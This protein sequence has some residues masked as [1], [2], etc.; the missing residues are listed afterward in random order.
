MDLRFRILGPVEAC[1]ERR[2]L[3]LG[4]ARASTV[5]T[6]LLLS[7]NRTVSVE[8]LI[9]D[10]WGDCPPPTAR[11]LVHS[12]V[13]RLRAQLRSAGAPDVIATCPGGYAL[14]V[15]HGQVD[16]DDFE[17]LVGEAERACSEDRL[18]VAA[19]RLRDALALWRGP[20]LAGTVSEVLTA[21]A[22]VRLEERRLDVLE[23]RIEADLRLGRHA[24]V[25]GELEELVARHPLRERALG[26]LMLALYRSDRQADSL[27]AYAAARERLRHELGVDP[28][29][30]LRQLE[31]RIRS[32]DPDLLLAGGP[33]DRTGRRPSHSPCLLPPDIG[34]WIG[35]AGEVDAVSGALLGEGPEAA[36]VPVVALSGPPGVGKTAFAVHVAHLLSRRFPDGQ[37]FMDLGGAEGQ[38]VGP[39]QVHGAFLRALGVANAAVPHDDVERAAAYRASLTGRRV[40]VVLDNAADEGQVRPLLPGS[41]GCA[42][43]VTSRATL[44]GLEAGSGLR[45]DVLEPKPALDLL[46]SVTGRARVQAELPAARAI[47]DLCGGLPLALRIAGARLRVRPHWRLGRLAERLQNERRRLDELRI[48]DLE[49]RASLALS[50][51]GLDEDARRA[52][53]FLALLTAPDF[54]VWHAAALLDTDLTTAED[55]LERLVDA[56]LLQAAGEDGVGQA[57]YR[58]H[59]LVRTFALERGAEHDPPDERLAA[60]ER[61]LAAQLALGELARAAVSP[62]D[63]SLS[64]RGTA[65]RR[66]PH[67]ALAA[68]AATEPVA[69]LEVERD[70][71]RSA[72]EMACAADLHELAWELACSLP[73]FLALRGYWHDWRANKL[74]ALAANRRAGNRAG[75]AHMTYSLGMSAVAVADLAVAG[76]CFAECLVAYRDVGSPTDERRSLLALGLIASLTGDAGAAERQYR[77]C[78][79]SFE[80]AG[81]WYGAALAQHGLADLE[82][83]RGQYAEA[84]ANL[85]RCLQVFRT[86]G[87][88]YWE[89]SV[90]RVLGEVAARRG[91]TAEAVGCFERCLQIATRL[92]DSPLEARVLYR[93]GEVHQANG[94]STAAVACLERCVA[95]SSTQHFRELDAR[96]RDRLLAARRPRFGTGR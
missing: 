65:P 10:V 26:L 43:I 57:R 49:V 3:P 48:G 87:E 17:D 25:L 76:R 1:V 50:D 31:Q 21:T 79:S 37:L 51:R 9:D 12:Y 82:R 96:A 75:V 34:D 67:T 54:A 80:A 28:Q 39:A 46:G 71:L 29:P 89:A 4:G 19:D 59:L 93:L 44:G 85:E 38:P 35:R 30:V 63:A 2:V 40:L 62:G 14:R 92:N 66:Q 24:A 7:A 83:K 15:A 6:I 53:R 77:R 88:P 72:V 58:L 64:P 91:Q 90:L 60:T 70:D 84:A 74:L 41:P 27:R 47:V 33:G 11:G 16:L 68:V 42:V 32:A 56:Q 81:Q 23:R 18:E 22:V 5:H 20:A 69:L 78:L 36:T 13:S 95:V 61:V 52:L 45:L 94:D 73:T 86:L 8:Q 55:L